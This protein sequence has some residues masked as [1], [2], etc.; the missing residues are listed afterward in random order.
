M[1][2]RYSISIASGLAVTVALCAIFAFISSRTGD[3]RVFYL[4]SGYISFFAGCAVCAISASKLIS[5]FPL[6]SASVAGGIFTLVIVIASLLVRDAN[7]TPFVKSMI[8]YLLGICLCAVI[9]LLFSRRT[10]SPSKSRKKMM[11]R[12]KKR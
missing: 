11:K 8:L 1:V 6:A 7:S 12:M 10:S 5:D 4:P 2:K 9:G 3:A